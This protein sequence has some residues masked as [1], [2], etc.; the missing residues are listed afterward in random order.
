MSSIILQSRRQSFFYI[1]SSFIVSIS[2]SIVIIK[3]RMKNVTKLLIKETF[4]TKITVTFQIF[5]NVVVC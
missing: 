3:I 4:K 2:D 1:K 5:K